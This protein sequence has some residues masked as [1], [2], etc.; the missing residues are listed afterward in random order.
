MREK[1]GLTLGLNKDTLVDTGLE[2]AVEE[3]VEHGVA[4][5]QLVVGLDI[6]LQA[7]TAV[8]ILLA[9]CSIDFVFCLTPNPCRDGSMHVMRG[10]KHVV[11]VGNTENKK[12]MLT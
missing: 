10:M 2:G 8:E 9:V 1:K 7:L 3:G 11:Q 4:G 5:I 12:R 6:L